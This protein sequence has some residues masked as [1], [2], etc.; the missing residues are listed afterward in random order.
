MKVSDFQGKVRSYNGSGLWSVGS[1]RKRYQEYCATCH[2]ESSRSLAPKEFTEGDVHWIYPV[3]EEV[4]QGIEEGDAACVALGID[5]V[6]EDGLFPF[7]AILKSNTA[8]ALRRTKLTDLQ[9]LA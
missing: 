1:V 4:I 6:E 8:R 9:N 5:F 7:G 3:M 2:V